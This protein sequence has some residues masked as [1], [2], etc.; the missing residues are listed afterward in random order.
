MLF[1]VALYVILLFLHFIVLLLSKAHIYVN[2]NTKDKSEN[3]FESQ[4]YH[5]WKYIFT[6]KK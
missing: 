6:I 3:A 4:M 1:V 5:I 2:R